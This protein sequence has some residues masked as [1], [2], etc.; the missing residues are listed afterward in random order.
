MPRVAS[1]EITIT[2]ISDGDSSR[3]VYLFQNGTSSPTVPL[4]TAGFVASTGV[5]SGTGSWSTTATVPASGSTLYVASLNIR[6]PNS[7]GNWEAVGD[8]EANPSSSSGADGGTGPRRANGFIYR[9]TFAAGSAPTG[10]SIDWST[11][12]L[13]PPTGGW[14]NT[15]PSTTSY[16]NSVFVS[17]W[18]AS[19]ADDRLSTAITYTVPVIA[20]V[21]VN[22]IK[23]VNFDG[24]VDNLIGPNSNSGT[25][26]YAM[27]ASTGT[28]VFSN[29]IVRGR[30]TNEAERFLNGA[31]GT[32]TTITA[33]ANNIHLQP[34][35]SEG[36]GPYR[37]FIIGAGGGGARAAPLDP[38][39]PG[40]VSSTWAAGGGGAGGFAAFTLEWDGTT[41][42]DCTV[43]SGGYSIGRVD[44]NHYG[45]S[46]G[47]TTFSIGSSVVA[48]CNG[49]GGGAHQL[50]STTISSGGPGGTAT[51]ATNALIT[52]TAN[53]VTNT[54]GSGGYGIARVYTSNTTS[55]ACGGG[56]GVNFLSKSN[57][58]GG[59]A[60]I[61][62]TNLRVG[63]GHIAVAGGGGGGIFGGGISVSISAASDGGAVSGS[64][65]VVGS[66]RG[67]FGTGAIGSFVSG[68][69]SG[70]SGGDIAPG[71][72]GIIGPYLGSLAQG[73]SIAIGQPHTG[74]TSGNT[75]P[76][77]NRTAIMSGAGGFA[78][79][80]GQ[81]EIPG[82]EYKAQDGEIFGGGG[83]A[84]Y[85]N[86]ALSH[87]SNGV[88]NAPRGGNGGFGAGGGAGGSS[89]ITSS[90]GGDGIIL[91]ARL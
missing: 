52:D 8:W 27:D 70:G 31:A 33:S 56:G 74:S 82:F 48:T 2:N 68:N 19:E 35:F 73:F 14:S 51:I 86:S 53:N 89:Q 64:D 1:D 40:I 16:G 6:Q 61:G 26:G 50:S 87:A 77:G 7:T 39:T 90:K 80:G 32:W 83:G 81:A 72:S 17:Y 84:A 71:G 57:T 58:N 15:A 88:A 43:G 79:A 78:K 36:A 5:A 69:G 62:A 91:I 3:T 55:M 20:Q 63:V 29:V 54:G 75:P 30:V 44:L 22:D 85:A 24:T 47:A 60:S 67:I 38:I 66:G 9:S 4:N 42:L 12:V 65:V 37:I 59:N 23:S 13:T 25:V 11:G 10:G 45:N 34:A 49:G 41:A 76:L 21:V 46:G 28:A 18:A